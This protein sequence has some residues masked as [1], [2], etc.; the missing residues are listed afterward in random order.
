M[1]RNSIIWIAC[2]IILLE[3][4]IIGALWFHAR[5]YSHHL[6]GKLEERIKE[7]TEEKVRELRKS[8]PQWVHGIGQPTGDDANKL[9]AEE[10]PDSG[11]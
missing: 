8:R 11:L 3:I 5:T 9:L 1:L 7:H 6:R 4:T 2:I 10:I